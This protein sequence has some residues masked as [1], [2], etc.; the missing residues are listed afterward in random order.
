MLDFNPSDVP[1][2]GCRRIERRASG[3]MRAGLRS[4]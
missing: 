4:F 1:P 3:G 2:H